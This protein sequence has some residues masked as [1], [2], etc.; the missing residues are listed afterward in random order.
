MSVKKITLDNL[1]KITSNTKIVHKKKT[2]KTMQVVGMFDLVG[3]TSL[4]IKSGHDVGIQHI[5]FH[6]SICK[7]IIEELGGTIVKNLG[8]GVLAIFNDPVKACIA[9]INIRDYLKKKQHSTK[10][11]LV[12]GY[13]EQ[14]EIDGKIDFLGSAID[15][16]SRIEKYA[17]PDQILIHNTLHD[18]AITHLKTYAS[19]HESH[20]LSVIIDDQKHELYEITSDKHKL[21]NSL[22]LPFHIHEKGRLSLEEKISFLQST[23][24]EIIEIGTGLKQFTE[25]LSRNQLDFK[26]TVTELLQKGV[27]FRLYMID[28]QWALRTLQLKKEEKKYFESMSESINQLKIIR[29]EFRSKKFKGSFQLYMYQHYPLFHVLCVDKDTPNG[30]MMISNYMYGIKRSSCPVLQLLKR[31][32]SIMYDTYVSSINQVAKDSKLLR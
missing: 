26:K 27:I 21:H 11:S 6:N 20:P 14:I 16:C 31:T 1:A 13:V 18:V 30:K 4:K 25:Y 7:S 17:F 22:K 19:F 5:L 12:L 15:L 2:I 10:I 28:S 29:D 3:S 32:N 9:S 8:D 23:T 24:K